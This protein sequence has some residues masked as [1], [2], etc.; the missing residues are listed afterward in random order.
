MKSDNF[1]TLS[2]IT[3]MLLGLADLDSQA[4]ENIDAADLIKTQEAALVTVKYVLNINMGSAR[5]NQEKESERELTCSMISADGLLACSNNQLGGFV[6]MISRM[7]GPLGKSISA[8]PKNFEVLVGAQEQ[9]FDAEIMAIDTELDIVWIRITDTRGVSFSFIDF[10]KDAKAEIG[11]TAFTIRR[12]SNHFG[13][14]PVVS[15]SRIGGIT[16]K[17]RKLLI[18]EAPSNNTTG[19]PVFSSS[20]RVIGLMVTQLPEAGENADPTMAMFGAGMAGLQ[21]AMSGLILPAKEVVKATQRALE[22][23]EPE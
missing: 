5:G 4:S 18:L 19:L 15:Q 21:D 1:K 13:R 3:V 7:A 23:P 9:S 22:T 16:L 6:S 12:T 14:A 17:P 10:S 11:D 8:T 2:F 20:G